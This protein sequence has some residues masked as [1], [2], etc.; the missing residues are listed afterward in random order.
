MNATDKL[1]DSFLT[2]MEAAGTLATTAI[3]ITAKHGQNPLNPAAVRF[4]WRLLA[5]FLS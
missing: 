2:S 4:L 1:I 3:I 5:R